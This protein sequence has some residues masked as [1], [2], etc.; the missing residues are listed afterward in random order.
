MTINTI[1]ENDRRERFIA[2]GGQTAFPFDFPVYE[3]QHV[4]VFRLRGST[5][6]ELQYGTHYT[7]TGAGDQGGGTV[8]LLTGAEA[9]DVIVLISDQPTAR[10]SSYANGGD[11]TAEALNSD[12]NRV[13]ITFQQLEDRLSRTIRIPQGDPPGG[14][15]LP[16]APVR[17]DSIFAFDSDGNPVM[18]Q[19]DISGSGVDRAY[20]QLLVTNA[21]NRALPRTIINIYTGSLL[22]IPD[23]WQL[24]DGTNGTPNMTDRFVV[25]FGPVFP[26]LSTG[27]NTSATTSP[28]GGHAHGGKTGERA[29]TVPQLPPH[30]HG[31]GSNL[32]SKGAGGGVITSTGD[33]ADRPS[34]SE[35]TGEGLP[36]DHDITPAD[37]HQHDVA[38]IP[39]FFAVAFIARTGFFVPP[40]DIG[41]IPDVTEAA[42]RADMTIACG[43][44]TTELEA[45]AA[46]VSFR[47]LRRRVLE[48]LRVTLNGASTSGV[49]TVDVNV[50]GA[51]ILS[52][53]LTIDQGELTSR[54]AA[55]P[56]VL[57]AEAIE[58]DALVTI[59]IDGAG[60]DATG[61]KI[62]F[63]MRYST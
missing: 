33:Y 39:P 47:M 9:A 19:P 3:P 12:G 60:A 16:A 5:E 49:V 61:L 50:D 14:L 22:D 31:Q 24:A 58:D 56:A 11:L 34:E 4:A 28:N 30:K 27:G 8:N 46:K 20:V 29:L 52:T 62:H 40:P 44:E 21:V 48:G 53:K 32:V 43:D 23:G 36:H 57:T 6:T 41:E 2:S 38:T 63:M 59:D 15:V 26:Y 55:V 17:A 45:G 54:T 35:S 42:L 51:T 1:P 13:Y 37:N 18:L 25:G 10:T 7:V